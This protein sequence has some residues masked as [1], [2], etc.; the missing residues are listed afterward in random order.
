MTLK[1]KLAPPFTMNEDGMIINRSGE[2]VME[3][4]SPEDKDTDKWILDKLNK[5]AEEDFGK[6]KEEKMGKAIYGFETPVS[7]NVCEIKTSCKIYYKVMCGVAKTNDW[8]KADDCT[9]SRHADCPLKI[10]SDEK[11]YWVIDEFGSR[12]PDCDQPGNDDNC[13]GLCPPYCKYCGAK[14]EDPRGE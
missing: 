1:E 4:Y 12:C 7:C 5:A 11:K 8:T 6:P 14:L 3:V 10:E 2:L 13:A 9:D